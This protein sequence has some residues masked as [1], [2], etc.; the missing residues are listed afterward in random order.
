MK[1]FVGIDVSSKTLD[2]CY[3]QSDQKVLNQM[4]VDNSLIG[5]QM[6]QS[7]ILLYAKQAGYEAIMIG[8]ESTSVYSFHPATFLHE[9]EA[10]KAL[11]VT[12]SVINPTK[13]HR[14]KRM[15]DEDKTDR[16]DAYRIAD[17][18]RLDIHQNSLIKEEQYI[19]LQRLTRSRYQLVTQLTECKQHF[20]ENLY[21]KCNT[22]TQSIDTSV[23][24][25]T[26]MALLTEDVTLDEIAEMPLED[27]ADFLNTKGR[28][29]FADSEKLAKA[30][31]KAIRSAYR[32]GQV[33][34]DSVD[35]VLGTY[36]MLIKTYT[37]QIK[38]LEKS[39]ERVLETIPEAQCLLSIPGIARVYTA[40]IIAEIG[41]IER[42]EN[43]A[44]LAKY[45]GL[46]W[47][48]NQ[49]GTFTAQNTPITKSGNHYLRYYLIEA[50]NSVR[51]H[52]PTFGEYYQKKKAEVPKHQHKRALV[53]T[54]RKFVR[55]VDVLLRNH[56]L[57]MPERS[58]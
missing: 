38:T 42:F 56:Q 35:Q 58:V 20:I 40:G 26:M 39:I 36:A 11:N 54:A 4:T 28:G 55:L 37:K 41:Q 7:N 8:L 57:Y 9:D 13:I 43:Q 1:L 16:V 46:Y 22:L 51:N 25:A 34:A 31:Q 23:F 29:R 52:V 24:G 47:K 6:I 48:K 45:A 33:V 18:L 12:V 3:L 19:A 15:F 32:L 44:K 30:I 49:S 50:T 21:Y 17:F 53:L 27:L 10:L 2:V 14:F 5:A